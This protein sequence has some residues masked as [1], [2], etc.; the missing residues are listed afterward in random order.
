MTIILAQHDIPTKG[1]VNLEIKHSFEIVTTA[2]EAK[3]KTNRWL[4]D[5]VSYMM[6]AEA[7]DL[8]IGDYV[9]W[10]VPVVLTATHKG[11]VGIV[12]YVDVHVSTGQIVDEK[13]QI[14]SLVNR[15][16][17]LAATLPNYTSADQIPVHFV[18]QHLPQAGHIETVNA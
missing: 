16:E 9:A 18:P 17:I 15:A 6:H 10:R 4:L 8:V 1:K 7:P 5:L 11:R 12:G 13:A 14:E 2:E 3:H